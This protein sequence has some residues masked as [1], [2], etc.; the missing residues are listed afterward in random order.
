MYERSYGYRYEEGTKLSTVEIAKLIRKAIKQEIGEGLLPERWKYSVRSDSFAGGSSIDVRVTDCADAW[1]V[2]PGYKIGSKV[3][4]EGGGWTATG[5]GNPW[6]K[7]GGEH[8][9]LPGAEEHEVLTAEAEAA[10]IT[11]Q[12]IHGAFNHDGS[13]SMVDYFDVN[14][15]GHVEFESAWAARWAAEEKARKAARKA[16]MAAAEPD[17]QV[18]VYGRAGSTVHAAVKV[19]G[20]TKLACGARLWGSSVASRTDAA[21]TCSRCAK[22]TANGGA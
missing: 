7:A 11:L 19:D 14:Y 22:K 15:Y 4:H 1:V 2:C 17:G 21:V 8:R 12:R 3:E 10:K 9:D 16:A 13:D 5:C 18:V 20:K 6:C